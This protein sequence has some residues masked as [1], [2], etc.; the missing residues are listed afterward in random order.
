MVSADLNLGARTMKAYLYVTGTIFTLFA[1]FHF[2]L[3]F[4]HWRGPTPGVWLVLAPALIA[5]G[6]SALAAWAFQLTRRHGRGVA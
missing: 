1:L 6:S 4:E 3:T 2:F 5:L